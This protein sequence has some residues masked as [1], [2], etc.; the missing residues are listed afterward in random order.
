MGIQNINRRLLLGPAICVATILL[1]QGCTDEE[2]YIPTLS[3]DSPLD[4]KIRLEGEFCAEAADDLEAFLK[5]TLIIDRSNS[6]RVTDANENRI[7]AARDLVLRF[8]EDKE[9]YRLRKGVEFA[10]ISF[11]GDS[12]IHTRNAKGLPGFSSDGAQ[13]LYEILQRLG[14]VGANTGYDKALA[15]AFLVINTDMAQLSEK[16]KALSRYETVFLSDGLPF[17]D[18]CP[19]EANSRDASERAVERLAALSILHRVPHT[20]HT[21]FV[22]APDMFNGS[23]DDPCTPG[24]DTGGPSVGKVTSDLLKSMADKGG[25]TFTRFDNGDSI[26]FDGF[27]FNEARRIFGLTNFIASN[28][29]ARPNDKFVLA[30]SDGDGLSDIEEDLVGT[31]PYLRDSDFD[32]YSD[33]LEWSLRLS[34]F[35]PLDPTDST[36]STQPG[37]FD[38]DDGDSLLNCE[39][40]LLQSFRRRF[41]TDADRI[42]DEV[43]L[44]FGTDVRSANA[45]Q[46]EQA[47]N[48]ADGGSNAQE[49][50]WHTDPNVDD[51]G[52]RSRV[53]YD[54]NLRRQPLNSAQTCYNFSVGNIA[55]A[56]TRAAP[57][58]E[59]MPGM[60]TQDGWN[61][62]KF[63]FAQAPRD[64]PLSEPVYRIGCIDARYIEE[65]DLKM[66]ASGS[67]VIPPRRPSA[68]WLPTN[69]RSPHAEICNAAVNQDCG[70][71][72]I[73][74][75]IDAAGTCSCN[76][77]SQGDIDGIPWA[78]TGGGCPECANGLDDDGDGLTDF[79]ADPDCFDSADLVEQPSV[80]CGNGLDDDGDGD[81]DWPYD[82]GC[83]NGTVD[84]NEGDD[85]ATDTFCSDGIDNDGDDLI[86]MDDPGCYAAVDLTEGQNAGTPLAA[87]T[88]G[89]DN[90]GDG[91]IDL[92]DGGCFDA[93]DIDE[94]G[95]AA[96]FFCELL[97]ENTPGQC[98]I[99]AGLCRPRSGIPPTGNCTSDAECRGGRCQPDG[100]CAACLSDADCDEAAGDFCDTD[101]GWCLKPALVNGTAREVVTPCTTDTECLNGCNIELGFCNVDPYY[102]CRDDKQCGPDERCAKG[103]FCLKTIFTTAQCGSNADCSAGVCDIER[104][105]CL[106]NLG[107]EQCIHNDQC[108]FGT[109]QPEGYCDQQTFVFPEDFDPAV[110]CLRAR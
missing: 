66:P 100:R 68:T 46:E 95:P 83:D 70:L 67:F 47:D 11:F 10:L 64:D 12:E 17:P 94:S 4:N 8:V 99:G 103:G 38:D 22:S 36:C 87:C 89:F 45:V 51:V 14:E 52:Y 104:G 49:I 32:G 102:A 3:L 75:R 21:A 90:D 80:Q 109:C 107:S 25:G 28:I 60:E 88:D 93:D 91:L 29:N 31:S 44:R 69:T 82:A 56:N 79:P 48:D 24:F 101:A 61:R 6:M 85:P 18:N 98:N 106:P 33:R 53:A 23:W 40:D 76:E 97:S 39:E 77:P 72:S 62:L 78:R 50:R 92:A 108:P 27:E 86:D 37:G 105:W 9:T 7:R 2:L 57:K 1:L 65:R 13:I 110:D 30:D 43:E 5:I 42:P 34:G 55:L 16:A 19:G 71:D 15:Q 96:C 59:L 74:C 26:S 35:D 20:L 73:W 81:I 54:Y 84:N 63:Y 58:D 41:D